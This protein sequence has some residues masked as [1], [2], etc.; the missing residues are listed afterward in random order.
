VKLVS[1][2]PA[3]DTYSDVRV[4]SAQLLPFISNCYSSAVKRL[5]HSYQEKRPVAILV[6]EGRLGP[7]HVVDRFLESVEDGTEVI[8]IDGTCAD[9]KA[10]MQEVVQHI[11]FEPNDMSIDDLE[12]VFEL[13]LQYQS[14]HKLR[15]IIA[16]QD[17]HVH[18]W[19]VLD[20]I[21]RLVEMEVEEKY[22]LKVI[23]S[24]PPSVVTVINEPILDV[25]AAA[26]GDRIV[27]TPFTLTETRNYIRSRSEMLDS[28]NHNMD[29]VSQ[30]FEF[31][32]VTLI[33]E[34]CS[35]VPDDVHELC[36]KCLDIF[37]DT[38]QKPIS[39]DT[40]KK[41][42]A[43]VGLMP[44]DADDQGDSSTFDGEFAVAPLGRLV[45]ETQGAEIT[46]TFLDQSCFLIGR[47]RICNICIQGLRVS[48][49]HA[50]LSMSTKGL[51][52]ADLGS[53]NGT[54]VNG[55]KVDRFELQDGDVVAIGDTRI[56][57]VAG[58]E[59]LT[60]A[61]D[62]DSTDA[63]EVCEAAP[64]PCITYLGRDMRLIQTS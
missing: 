55:E 56:T 1:I 27:L 62:I 54:T 46:E 49:L 13:F 26:A 51:H 20:K 34:I 59:Q 35:G 6:S 9:P 42:A 64:D 5:T 7:I 48:R 53:T 60:Q 57:Y 16:I 29:D 11:G 25:I 22:G 47:D 2:Q 28:A 17:S 3:A 30:V 8:R 33:H 38:G 4:E 37:H 15:T 40:V 63:F 52:V 24:G 50:V 44:F 58:A 32:A 18:G 61:S 14:K 23:V 10:F 39:I 19:W 41:A 12:K 36:S 43:L 45:V 21:R 31:L